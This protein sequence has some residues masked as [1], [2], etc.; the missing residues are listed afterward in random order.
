M[1]KCTVMWII[2]HSLL[3]HWIDRNVAK[4]AYRV[5]RVC[6]FLLSD[7]GGNVGE[8]V[9]MV[10]CTAIRWVVILLLRGI[11]SA[12]V[13]PKWSFLLMMLLV[14]LMMV[15]VMMI[16]ATSRTP[17]L[18]HSLMRT[19]RRIVIFTSRRSSGWANFT[20]HSVACFK[21]SDGEWFFQTAVCCRIICCLGGI[22]IGGSCGR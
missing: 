5:W 17:H 16:R 10:G 2:F 11:F 3:L 14:M 6:A 1:F 20:R 4:R 9:M 15:H 18:S 8:L 21:Q 12:I 7:D 22:R 19:W 13:H